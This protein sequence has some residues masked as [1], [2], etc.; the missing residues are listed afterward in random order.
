MAKFIVG[1]TMPLFSDTKMFLEPPNTFQAAKNE[2]L[3]YLRFF[4]SGTPAHKETVANVEGW[5]EENVPL[6]C[7]VGVVIVSITYYTES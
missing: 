7:K 1:Y 3:Q 4:N 6:S 5:T 2:V